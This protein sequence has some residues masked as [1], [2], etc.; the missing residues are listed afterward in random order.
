[1][2]K[3]GIPLAVVLL[4][5]LLLAL[6]VWVSPVQCQT[7]T[8]ILTTNEDSPVLLVTVETPSITDF[9]GNIFFV[10][11]VTR[12]DKEEAID[13]SNLTV[14][15]LTEDNLTIA[16]LSLDELQRE[17]VGVY[18]G[19][20]E[21]IGAYGT[22][23]IE[24]I[25]SWDTPW[26]TTEIT[27][28][29]TEFELLP[30]VNIS[31]K[32]EEWKS[33]LERKIVVS[34]N[35]TAIV[36]NLT[37]TLENIASA[38]AHV[39]NIS[40]IMVKRGSYECPAVWNITVIHIGT[41]DSYANGTEN[42]ILVNE[43]IDKLQALG[44]P[45]TVNYVRTFAE[46]EA[47]FNGESEFL[48]VVNCHGEHIPCP[49]SKTA[50]EWTNEISN[51][52]LVYRWIWLQIGRP[53]HLFLY[54]NGTTVSR[55]ME[56]WWDFLINTAI[57][58]SD[59]K[60]YNYT[61]SPVHLTSTFTLNWIESA[62][63]VSLPRSDYCNCVQVSPEL[64][65]SYAY[66]SVETG[67]PVCAQIELATG[68][69][70]VLVPKLSNGNY[71]LLGLGMYL[72]KW[73]D[74][75]QF[76]TQ[77][78]SAA[79]DAFR[80][81]KTFTEMASSL[82]EELLSA[83]ENFNFSDM[84]ETLSSIYELADSFSIDYTFEIPDLILNLTLPDLGV[85]SDV[86][87]YFEQAAARMG[88]SIC[89]W[90][91][92]AQAAQS[93]VKNTIIPA[94]K[95][96]ADFAAK[97]AKPIVSAVKKAAES[98]WDGAKTLINKA[99]DLAN[100]FYKKITA[101]DQLEAAQRKYEQA[102][103]TLKATLDA[104]NFTVQLATILPTLSKD[105]A[106]EMANTLKSRIDQVFDKLK[107]LGKLQL[108][109]REHVVLYTLVGRF[110]NLVQA[111]LLER[112]AL[113]LELINANL[114]VVKSWVRSFVDAIREVRDWIWA[115]FGAAYNVTERL[116]GWLNTTL[117]SLKSVIEDA[118][119][120]VTEYLNTT[121]EAITEQNYELVKNATA[122]VMENVKLMFGQ[123]SNWVYVNF[124][125]FGDMITRWNAKFADMVTMIE[126]NLRQ[127]YADIAHGIV[128]QLSG[129]CTKLHSDLIRT[130]K[131]EISRCWGAIGA[132]SSNLQKL[133]GVIK[134]IV[135]FIPKIVT[136]IP[137]VIKDAIQSVM[138]LA[139]FDFSSA[140]TIS[141]IAD[142]LTRTSDELDKWSGFFPFIE[143]T[144]YK[145]VHTSANR[146]R[147]ISYGVQH[148]GLTE[149]LFYSLKDA[150]R[151]LAIIHNSEKGI[152]VISINV[153]RELIILTASGAR[154]KP[155]KSIEFSIMKL[156]EVVFRA[157]L[158]PVK[159]GVFRVKLPIW[160][161]AGRY[162]F[163][164]RITGSPELF[165]V[166]E[167]D[168]REVPRAPRGD[169]YLTDISVS[170]PE[171]VGMGTSFPIQITA[172]NTKYAW[173]TI[174]IS[175]EIIAESGSLANKYI[176]KNVVVGAESNL[177][178]STR[179][180]A[181]FYPGVYTVRITF[182]EPNGDVTFVETEV[183]VTWTIFGAIVWVCNS[184]FFDLAVAALLAANLAFL[185]RKQRTGI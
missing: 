118:F 19:F 178:V 56:G 6:E 26:G 91:S 130:L 1:M 137:E 177:T 162:L 33:E 75:V 52:I 147:I 37:G 42:E 53:F 14:N 107:D 59:Y 90:S 92:L 126:Q 136:V 185:I 84:N 124:R 111:G 120:N 112:A 27:R 94:A 164:A 10:V 142:N 67:M 66:Q 181:P 152:N 108:L 156:G 160:V 116:A 40:D 105:D 35:L 93:F 100:K 30:V 41:L 182:I 104:N 13:P 47:L 145:Y 174:D 25:A 132:I 20:F 39:V 114:E 127:G 79:I 113:V 183:F 61:Y 134:E 157:N 12:T 129:Y 28:A 2:R 65:V 54:S 60:E 9:K 179:V 15:L 62:L 98:A 68:G 175:I 83:W 167:V 172:Y 82:K 123:F 3:L 150:L 74:V 50:E 168:V 85:P 77:K 7:L 109:S 34:L 4:F 23:K 149:E 80:W 99:R 81:N 106:V 36:A 71:I 115:V 88:L 161:S 43:S 138:N 143:K 144:I 8:K 176:L 163:T 70:I 45:L 44:V 151:P 171:R 146:L 63:D 72:D 95:A 121:L 159:P 169:I 89:I 32:V 110:Q 125:E 76:L 38:L 58:I 48:I 87:S 148:V 51:K 57:A 16:S 5:S 119:G 24:A 101:E 154:L 133:I 17:D 140:G 86:F 139:R 153:G 46:L 102:L 64:T 55:G 170:V 166:K 69:E 165:D 122:K 131:V 173:N 22:F 31:Q 21:P 97:V 73:R 158:T 128:M 117:G 11:V 29:V 180:A 78:L 184:P 103:D 141:S 96:M 49:D 135:T 155:E 18:H